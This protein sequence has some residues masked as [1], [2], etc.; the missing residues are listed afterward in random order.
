M[1]Y[2]SSPLCPGIISP[3]DQEDDLEISSSISAIRPRTRPTT[4]ASTRT[5]GATRDESSSF[6]VAIIEGR[7]F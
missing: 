5:M 2:L 3:I 7:G 1:S 6:V 4:S